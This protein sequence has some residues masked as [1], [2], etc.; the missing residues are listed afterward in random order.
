[1]GRIIQKNN[2][3]TT[4][5]VTG[6]NFNSLPIL[7]NTYYVGV[8]LSSG[9]FEKLNPSGSIINLEASGSTFTGGT[10]SGATTFTNGLSANTM[11]AT[12]YYGDGS[13]L[14]GINSTEF[15]GGTV[16]GATTF[17]NGLSAN[18][19]SAT[20]FY[21]DGSNLTGINATEVTGF[22]FNIGNYE[23]E[24]LQS[25]DNNFNVDLSILASDMTITGGTY[26]PNTGTA[27]FTNNSGGTFD[28]TGFLTGFTDNAIITTY[29]ELVSD[30]LDSNLLAGAFYLISDYQTCYDQP[31]FDYNGNPITVGIYKQG[32]IEPLVVLATSMNT[33]STQ[34][35]QPLY[36]NDK[37]TYDWSFSATEV[38]NSVSFGRITERVDEFNNRTDYDHRNILFKR[39]KLFTIREQQPLNGTIELQNDGTVLGTDTYF[40]DLSVGDVIFMKANG[41]FHEIINIDDNT[42]MTVSGDTIDSF[43]CCSDFWLGI[44]ETNGS[45]YFS[46]KNTN[47]KS[48][49]FIE[50]TTFGDAISND[51]AINNYVGNY[52]NNYTNIGSNTF[53]LANN[54]FLEGQYESNKFG[55]YCYNNTFGTDNQNNVW[56]D[57]CYQNVSTNDIDDCTFG[58]YFNNNLIN[59]NLSNSKIGNYFEDNKILG[60]NGTDFR[61]NI[62]GDYFRNNYIY[63]DFY[64]NDILYGFE[65]NIIGD[66]GNLDNFN[67]YRNYIRNNFNE[68]I[69]RRTLQNNQIGTNFQVNTING[70]FIGNTILNGFNN[71][72]IGY[73]FS[74]NNIDNAFN[75]NTIYDNFYYNTT[76]YYFNSNIISN[77]FNTNKIGVY[78]LDNKPSNSDLFGWNDL[79]T[80]SIRTYDTLINSLNN[81]VNN[82]I[83]GKEFVMMVTSTSQYF[84]IK[85]TQWTQSGDGGGF[86]YERQEIDSSGNDIGSGIFFTKTNFGP[87]IDIVVPGVLELTRDNLGDL[88]NTIIDTPPFGGSWPGPSDTEWNSIYT[89]SNNGE[90]FA[91]NKIGNNFYNN[92]IGSDFGFGLG[93]AYGN[94]INDNFENNTIG[95]FAYNNVIGNEFKNNTIGDNFKDNT[96][97]NHFQGNEIYDGFESNEIGNYFGN[98]GG[99]IRNTIFNDFKFNK[100][101]NYFGNNTNYPT[102]GS[103]SGDDGGNIINDNFKYNIIGNN[104]IFN[105]IDLNFTNN[106]IGNDFW[107]NVFGLNTSDNTIG[108]LFVSNSGV[109]GFPTA[110]GDNFIS[111][112]LGN[113]SAF[114]EM[115]SDFRYNKIGDFFGNAGSGTQNVISVGFINNN[116]GNNFGDDG[117]QTDGGNY[118]LANFAY[119][120]LGNVFIL[121]TIEDDFV[122]NQ[123][124]AAFINNTIGKEFAS[125]SIGN[126]FEGNQIDNRFQSNQVG[127]SFLN[128]ILGN[129]FSGNTIG[130]DF[131]TN[132]IGNQFQS[133]TAGTD[134]FHNIL[135]NRFRY[136]MVGVNFAN[137]E[138]IN[139]FESNVI[140]NDFSYNNLGN[141]IN[142]NKFGNG[143]N[144]NTVINQLTNNTIGDDFSLNTIGSFFNNNNISTSF[145]NNTIADNFQRNQIE[146]SPNSIDF[147]TGPSTHVYGDYSCT[148]FKR[149]D[150]TLRLSYYDNSDVLNITNVDA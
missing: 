57:Y 74:V 130:D 128:N 95:Q 49:D 132:Q 45:G 129:Q 80:V 143:V 136:N 30:I 111:N 29:G 9:Y 6:E 24:L 48:D 117:S 93:D 13:N 87:E 52:A 62:I 71:N 124:G 41:K 81:D 55:D 149:P 11:S 141:Q 121:N 123:I 5:F 131:N 59:S 70:D 60:E 3:K 150:S 101:G 18:T 77:N 104:I 27:T 69:I 73:Y 10:V 107:F 125:N 88:Y 65:N 105:A 54:V 148:I 33:V 46:Y 34:A 40:T 51:Y 108:N 32:P 135:G 134:F 99:N 64:E 2:G 92:T 85:F 7:T 103:T 90:K 72:Q 116:I 127:D 28:V 67:F 96:I 50:Y 144:G 66:F 145:S 112:N 20:T 91:Y 138:V 102:D 79:S 15:T 12:T 4:V 89:Q 78:F 42:T 83:L 114:N 19:M 22:T 84:R 36:P 82:H 110:I 39:Y 94:I 133:N 68:N 31:D 75:G 122:G 126:L 137:N 56:G 25:N 115:D 23:L 14:T 16:S 76:D 147:T 142:S 53:I 113:Y 38:T 17:T 97:K 63:S 109:G 100:I 98:I 86:Q 61:S 139:L 26:D 21:G 47:V 120:K 118:I 44:E 119:N 1:M 106:K 146:Y 43:G 35:Y 37:I 140:G 8:D 58:Y